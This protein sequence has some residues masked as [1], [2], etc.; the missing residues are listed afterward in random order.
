MERTSGKTTAV[1]GK[2]ILSKSSVTLFTL[3]MPFHKSMCSVFDYTLEGRLVLLRPSRSS[4]TSVVF[5]RL[6][7]LN[8]GRSTPIGAF[9]ASRKA[10][11]C[12]VAL[13]HAEHHVL[14]DNGE[15]ES[16]LCC[17]AKPPESTYLHT[18]ATLRGLVAQYART[19]PSAKS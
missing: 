11:S 14:P 13:T 6:I 7:S 10:S 18:E 2:F 12:S 17:N 8:I 15:T 3:I 4:I 5:C 16:G 19:L 9:Y 1:K